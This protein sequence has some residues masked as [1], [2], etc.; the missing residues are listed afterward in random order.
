VLREQEFR[1]EYLLQVVGQ[2]KLCS[3]SR[4]SERSTYYTTS[5][6]AVQTVLREQEFRKSYVL[7][8]V[9]QFKMNSKTQALEAST[10]L[11]GM[12]TLPVI[13]KKKKKNT[14]SK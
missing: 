6:R 14:V 13:N 11:H 1:K 2:F 7:Q 9:G 12:P 3:E 10:V 8:V 4:S 5:G